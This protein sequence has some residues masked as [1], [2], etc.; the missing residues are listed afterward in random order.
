MTLEDKAVQGATPADATAKDATIKDVAKLA[1]VS[2]STV[3]YALSGKRPLSEAVRQRVEAAVRALDYAP[4]TL[5]RNLRRGS[6]RTVGLVY[7]L[8]VALTGEPVSDC[9]G[10]VADALGERYTLSLFS[11]A[12][13]P[14]GL[15]EALR[16]R[17]VDGLILMQIQRRDPRVEALRGGEHPVVLI[18]RPEDPTGLSLVDFDFEGAAYRSVE[19]LAR[20]GHRRVGYIDFPAAQ[21][22]EGLGYTFYLERGYRRARR[23]FAVDLVRQE[24]TTGGTEGGYRATCALLDAGPDL[25]AIVASV[26]NTQMGVLRALHAR[27]KVVPHDL[28]VVCLSTPELAAWTVPSLTSVD[29]PLTA[30]GREGAA[31]L[32]RKM[33]GEGRPQQV[34]F[35][36]EV[37]A[38]ESTA[39]PG[40]RRA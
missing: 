14:E 24:V 8:P 39:P 40:A 36:A 16:E 5:A 30:M 19:H 7:P 38:R 29:I 21:R 15:L 10:A 2:P 20:L 28:S 18:G 22:E 4:S 33:A 27:G 23:D 17:R 34:L 25:T 35:P 1:G 37:T 13:S 32:L 31:L 11:H 3:S 9:I 6:S 26:G 12:A